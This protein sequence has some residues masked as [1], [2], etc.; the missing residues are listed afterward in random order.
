MPRHPGI[1]YTYVFGFSGRARG[2]AHDVP[3][4][5]QAFEITAEYD[6]QARAQVRQVL[7][8]WVFTVDSLT[9]TRVRD[10]QRIPLIGA[11]FTGTY[12]DR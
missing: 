8:N 11:S 12:D 2:S 1:S 3:F 10:R 6:D 4:T 7:R 5:P 9:L